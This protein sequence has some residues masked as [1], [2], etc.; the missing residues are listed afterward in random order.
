MDVISCE[1]Y[2]KEYEKFSIPNRASQKIKPFPSPLQQVESIGKEKAAGQI[3]KY[4]YCYHNLFHISLSISRME[5]YLYSIL[6]A[7]SKLVFIQNHSFGFY[8]SQSVDERQI[9]C[10]DMD[11]SPHTGGKSNFFGKRYSL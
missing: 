11:R 7:F 6:F 5:E 8:P 4:R 9:L 3:I 10:F 2:R 1:G